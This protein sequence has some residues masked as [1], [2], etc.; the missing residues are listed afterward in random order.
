[1]VQNHVRIDFHNGLLSVGEDAVIVAL[2]CDS[3]FGYA[4]PSKKVTIAAN[5]ES[6]VPVKISGGNK[7][8]T[9]LLEPA[10]NL[11]EIMLASARTLV[12]TKNRGANLRVINPTDKPVNISPRSV[13][14]TVS[15]IDSAKVYPL[16]K[17][18]QANT[19]LN[20]NIDCSI[21]S[22]KSNL[23]FETDNTNLSKSEKAKSQQILTSEQ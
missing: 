6:V 3:R 5:S 15:P 2:L 1:M 10:T 21:H 20:I 7:N 23:K 13:L 18:E 22:A 16:S 8:D 11:H 19:V 9:V 4:R 17:N 14:A 12:K